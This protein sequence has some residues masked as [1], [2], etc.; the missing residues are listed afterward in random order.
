MPLY[1]LTEGRHGRFLTYAERPDHRSLYAAL[2]RMVRA[3]IWLYR[4]IVRPGDVIV[5]PGANIG[6]HSVYLSEA[7]GPE[8]RLYAFEPGRRPSVALCKRIA[9]NEC[10]N[11]HT[12]NQAIGAQIGEI[13][14]PRLD[15]ENQGNYGAVSM[16][17]ATEDDSSDWV[18]RREHI[19]NLSFDEA[20]LHQMRY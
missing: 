20:R 16:Y 18:E 9:L 19:D 13:R 15:P 1:H 5:E 2:W 17:G 11:V 4:Q 14:F 7:I 3:R 10:V 6:T 12:R 8:G